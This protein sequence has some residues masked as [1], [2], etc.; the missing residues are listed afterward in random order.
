MDI[1]ITKLRLALAGL[2]VLAGVGL[3]NLLS[4]LI[5]NALA[6]VGSTINIS[7]HSSS[8]YFAKVDSS[9]A[10]KTT[11][12][13]SGR[14][15]PALPPQPFNVSRL[16]T[17][18]T[19]YATVFGPTTATVALTDLAFSN[20]Y[21]NGPRRL[22]LYEYSAPAPNT[23]CSGTLQRWLALYDVA[24]AQTV[25]VDFQTPVVVKPLA[26][27]DAWCLKTE[28]VSAGNDSDF[29]DGLN[30]GG[31]VLSGTYTPTS[32]PGPAEPRTAMHTR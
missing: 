16:I 8:A 3:G 15:G 23:N 28:L 24:S 26:S 9:G 20:H 11:A 14:V 13:V 12:A 31:Y 4:P 18:S 22:V 17:A 30:L 27:G 5:G 19:G 1:R 25:S 10:L 2:F 6:T 7:D 21:V 32:A 29:T